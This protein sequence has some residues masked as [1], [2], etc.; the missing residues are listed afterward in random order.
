LKESKPDIYEKNRKCIRELI[1]YLQSNL[2][3]GEAFELYQ[4]WIDGLV[5]EVELPEQE[6]DFVL[7]LSTFQLGE[8]FDWR[9][10]QYIRASIS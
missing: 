1:A 5:N 8:Q 9:E 2:Q 10:R 4:S 7:N 3:A 6:P